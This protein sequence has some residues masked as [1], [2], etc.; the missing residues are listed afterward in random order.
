MVD[1]F[2][3]A[4][5]TRYRCLYTCRCRCLA[6]HGHT[7]R[8][9]GLRAAF[10]ATCNAVHAVRMP[11]A[12]LRTG[13]RGCISLPAHGVLRATARAALPAATARRRT[14]CPPHL[15]STARC[16]LLPPPAACLARGPVTRRALPRTPPRTRARRG[17]LA[18][19]TPHCHRTLSALAVLL[20]LPTAARRRAALPLLPACRCRAYTRCTGRCA[21]HVHLRRTCPPT[22]PPYVRLACQPDLPILPL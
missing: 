1:G 13:Y 8:T 15:A 19:P 2:Y 4:F 12:V 16:R 9:A 10:T 22:P 21:W 20:F 11:R 7:A 18:L 14:Y 6:C 17:A 5:W 3:Y